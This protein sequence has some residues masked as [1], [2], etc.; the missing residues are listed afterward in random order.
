M[1]DLYDIQLKTSEQHQE[2]QPTRIKRDNLDLNI[3]IT[4]LKSHNPFSGGNE[5][6]FNIASGVS[7]VALVNVDD[8]RRIG[9]E[10]MK[11]MIGLSVQQFTPRK[12]DQCVLMS[13]KINGDASPKISNIDPNLLFQRLMVVLASK[14]QEEKSLAEYFKYE[15]CSFPLS[16]FDSNC[17]LRNSNKSELAKE[18][19][20][21]VSYD[22][23]SEGLVKTGNE[24]FTFV[25]D[26]GWLLHR[27][28]WTKNERYSK[29]LTNYCDYFKTHYGKGAKVIFDGYE[30]PSTK[31]MTHVKRTKT[32]GPEV[33]FSNDMKLTNTKE[34]FLSN[35]RNKQ[36]FLIE[37]SKR[38][39]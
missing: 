26:G 11:K 33:V 4:Y 3:I 6:L 18:I 30:I 28:G 36:R 31:D 38:L 24:E 27:L 1:M 32:I 10:I 39:N 7:A 37:L 35:Y 13:Q 20:T 15:L 14:N 29:I 25:I 8:A 17:N 5:I 34:E 22:P 9:T 12:K 19:A 16:L 2:I 21:Q 23:G